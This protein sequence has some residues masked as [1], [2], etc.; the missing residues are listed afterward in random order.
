[1]VRSAALWKSALVADGWA[2]CNEPRGEVK[3]ARV[4]MLDF[5]ISKVVGSFRSRLGCVW[6][7]ASVPEVV[8]CRDKEERKMTSSAA[9]I[10]RQCR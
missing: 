5:G 6:R 1:M 9:F 3:A 8:R 7:K 2:K 4:F 10:G